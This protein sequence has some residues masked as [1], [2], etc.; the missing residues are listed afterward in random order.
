MSLRRKGEISAM[1]KKAAAPP[2]PS[3]PAVPK[4]VP[5]AAA[6][7]VPTPAP[8]AALPPHAAVPQV[9][10]PRCPHG[11]NIIQILTPNVLIAKTYTGF[12]HTGFCITCRRHRNTSDSPVAPQCQKH[13]VIGTTE[14]GRLSETECI[15]RLKRWYIGGGNA[16][17]EDSWPDG[18]KREYHVFHYGG[19]RL[20]DLATIALIVHYSEYLTKS[21]M[22][23]A[24]TPMN[25]RRNSVIDGGPWPCINMRH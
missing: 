5:A 21:L 20:K 14:E 7:A 12:E 17:V 9:P 19:R 13:I 11:G 16:V 25:R 23:C 15:R 6:P 2:Q 10:L 8:A 3:A 18:K 24:D 22:P 1:K 4:P